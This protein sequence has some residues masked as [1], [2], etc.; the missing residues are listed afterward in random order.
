MQKPCLLNILKSFQV[1]VMLL[2]STIVHTQKMTPVNVEVTRS[3]VKV[4]IAFYE[5]PVSALYLEK[6]IRDSHG[7]WKKD[8]SCSVDDPYTF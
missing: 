4:T 8:W 1:T 2:G 6:Y 3:K 7:T 5:K